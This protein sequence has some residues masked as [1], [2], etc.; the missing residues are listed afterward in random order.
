MGALPRIAAVRAAASPQGRGTLSIPI[1][2][3]AKGPVTLNY[4]KRS[5]RK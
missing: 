4:A 5:I 2:S 3:I 1:E